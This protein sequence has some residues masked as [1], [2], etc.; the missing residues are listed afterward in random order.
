MESWTVTILLSLFGGVMG[1]VIYAKLFRERFRKSFGYYDFAPEKRA[2]TKR[3]LYT[4][5]GVM[6]LLFVA[7]ISVWAFGNSAILAVAVFVV[8][9]FLAPFGVQQFRTTRSKHRSES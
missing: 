6:L 4:T 7:S 9:I 8:S 1:Y 5:W 3:I 2:A